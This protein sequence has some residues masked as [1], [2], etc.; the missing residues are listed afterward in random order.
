[1]MLLFVLPIIIIAVDMDSNHVF[2]VHFSGEV[3]S[4]NV[5]IK[6]RQKVLFETTAASPSCCHSK[7][8]HWTTENKHID[9]TFPMKKK[10][11][12]LKLLILFI[13]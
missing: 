13:T 4:K 7:R 10:S 2:C 8:G 3:Y 5:F 9:L 1:M 6:N 12:C 11:Q